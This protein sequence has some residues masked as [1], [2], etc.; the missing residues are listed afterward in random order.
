ME[1]TWNLVLLIV[2]VWIG[3]VIFIHGANHLL[4]TV[5]NQGVSEDLE[6]VGIR[7]GKVHAWAFSVVELVLAELLIVGIVTPVAFGVVAALMLVTFLAEQRKNGFFF[8]GARGWEYVATLGVVSVA[9]G[10]LGPGEWSLD[11]IADL[12][13]P[14]EPG[15]AL[16]I[17]VAI[18]VGLAGAFLAMFWRPAKL[19]AAPAKAKAAAA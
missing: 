10:A 17:T 2:R 18:A 1:D 8:T 16:I 5:R 11:W 6:K 12:T 9:M 4:R 3:I 19:S 13:F 15:T 14:F 7:P